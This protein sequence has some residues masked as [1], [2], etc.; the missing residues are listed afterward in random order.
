MT[1][2]AHKAH[3]FSRIVIQDDTNVVL[4]LII[5][6]DTFDSRSLAGQGNV[7]YVA[8]L[9]GP[10]SYPASSPDFNSGNFQM[11]DW[12]LVFEELPLPFVHGASSLSGRNPRSTPCSFINCSTG[13]VSVR[14]SIWRARS[15]DWRISSFS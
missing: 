10:Q 4:A 13:M 3:I 15:S 5:L 9:A 6:F 12:S 2:L 14:S 7:H 1:R 8:T 11:I